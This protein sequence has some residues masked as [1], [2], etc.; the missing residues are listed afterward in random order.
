[1]TLKA[2]SNGLER[3][4]E[5]WVTLFALAD[6][7]FK[8][9]GVSSASGGHQLALISAEWKDQASEILTPIL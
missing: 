3:T 9:L 5:G 1:M 6:P 4:V 2:F 8:F 7:R